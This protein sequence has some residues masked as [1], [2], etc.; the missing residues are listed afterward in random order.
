MA[1]A[2]HLCTCGV[3]VPEQFWG[4]HLH[5]GKHK[6]RMTRIKR[7]LAS[8]PTRPRRRRRQR[9]SGGSFWRY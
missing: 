9:S 4:D 3:H 6:T 8:L 1:R 5:G 2:L 7:G